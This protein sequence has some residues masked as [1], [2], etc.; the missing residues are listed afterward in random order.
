M[1]V[2]AWSRRVF[3]GYVMVVALWLIY[4]VNLTMFLYG[5][6][7]LNAKMISAVGLDSATV[8]I[9][10]S[11]CTVMQGVSG[12]VLGMLIVRKGVRTPMIFGTSLLIAGAFLIAF[13]TEHEVC[14]VVFYGLIVGTGMG[15]SGVLAVQSTVNCWFDR[16]KALAMALVLSAG[17]IGGF[18]VPLILN[19]VAETW[20]WRHGWMLIG[21]LGCVSLFISLFVVVGRPE[22]I[23]EIPDGKNCKHPAGQAREALC[24][25]GRAIPLREVYRSSAFYGMLACT[26]TR[27][28]LHYSIMGHL[29]IYLMQAGISSTAAALSLSVLSA[30]SLVGR[31]AVGLISESVLSPRTSASL[32]NVLMGIGMLI[33][34]TM[35][36]VKGVYGCAALIGLGFGSGYVSMPLTI[37]RYFGN[38]NFPVISGI[39]TPINHIFGGIGPLLAGILATATGSYTL[40][41]TILSLLPVAGAAVFFLT[42]PPV[43]RPE[44]EPAAATGPC[45]TS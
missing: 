44:E 22:D 14:F 12:P 20:S 28:A 11:L 29:V 23:A 39:T 27:S 37:S 9:A 43:C 42:K 45:K 18:V 17:G 13:F 34:N 33:I 2:R 32:G 40:A 6:A 10:V 26:A 21:A 38:D 8:G 7:V 3:Y 31:L 4:F 19:G 5:A 30:F 35:P 25:A 16:K 24:G 1:F 15:L 41:F 36:S